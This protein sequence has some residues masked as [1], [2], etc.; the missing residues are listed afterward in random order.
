MRRVLPPALGRTPLGALGFALML[1][2]AGA[3]LAAQGHAPDTTLHAAEHSALAWLALLDDA[4]YERAWPAVVGAMRA[5][6]TYSAWATSLE[7]LRSVLPHAPV[8]TLLRA[9][10]SVPLFGGDS[11]FL[12]FAIAG[13]GRREIVVLV[14]DGVRWRI[15]G[16]GV[17]L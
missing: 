3:P 14:R 2:F 5:S 6:T 7:T 9:E 8:R 11:V 15:G 1:L 13:S 4:D 16:Y 12:T 10:R 17:L